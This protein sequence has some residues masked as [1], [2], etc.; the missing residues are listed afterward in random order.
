M[1][2]NS[3]IPTPV[4]FQHTFSV[5]SNADVMNQG[6]YDLLYRPWLWTYDWRCSALT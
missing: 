6:I 3:N 5:M 4:R 2:E 1:C